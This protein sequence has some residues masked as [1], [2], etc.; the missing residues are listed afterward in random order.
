MV[1]FLFTKSYGN[2]TQRKS[3]D[4]KECLGPGRQSAVRDAFERYRNLFD[5]SGL[6]LPTMTKAGTAEILLG[7]VRVNAVA[8]YY[9]IPQLKELANTK[10]FS[11][12]RSAL[13]GT[14]LQHIRLIRA[15]PPGNYEI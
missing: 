11:S 7:H 5:S 4:L 3:E 6:P 10:N 12:S 2:P 1:E 15:R 14:C 9:D 8:D 13:F